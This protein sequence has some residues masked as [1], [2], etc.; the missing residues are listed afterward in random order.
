MR[1]VLLFILILMVG[2]TVPV[3]AANIPAIPSNYAVLDSAHLL[4]PATIDHVTLGNRQ[5]LF[6]TGGEVLFY[7]RNFV[8]LGQ[9]IHEYTLEVFN[10]WGLGH[11]EYNNGILV[12]LA[13]QDADNSYW[14]VVG[15]GIADYFTASTIERYLDTYFR[16]YF[17]AGEHDMAVITLYNA[18]S[19]S[20]QRLYVPPAGVAA[21]QTLPA[22]TIDLGGI[23]PIIVIIL[24]GL[25][26]LSSVSRATRYGG[27]MGPMGG[28]M[29][30]RRRG[31]GGFF[32][33]LLIGRALG[34]PRRPMGGF[35]PRPGVPPK[36]F[37]GGG[38]GGGYTRGGGFGGGIG[39]RG[40]GYT[41]VG[42]GYS[43]GGG[44][45]LSRG[46]GRRR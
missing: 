41:R 19:A 13:P 46:M 32:G 31:F 44:G 3:A 7:T 27:M 5:L 1:R 20:I 45:G 38:I 8:P 26:I 34:G 12:M 42:G 22:N 14:M 11:P 28:P 23:I 30:P 39:G 33:G 40:G 16:A 4:S 43:R 17:A 24:I 15:D 6:N 29:M 18:L 35:G 21:R 37:G 25:W 10:A 9:S 36:P 2:I